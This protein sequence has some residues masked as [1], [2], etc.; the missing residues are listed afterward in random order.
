[1]KL[2]DVESRSML[3]AFAEAQRHADEMC[4]P[5]PIFKGA[6]SPW[7][8]MLALGIAALCVVLAVS[9]V[10]PDWFLSD[11]VA[12]PTERPLGQQLIRDRGD[13]TF[14]DSHPV[15]GSVAASRSPS[16]QL[17]TAIGGAD[18]RIPK[19]TGRSIA[20]ELIN[21]DPA[22]AI[23]RLSVLT[24]AVVHGDV[25]AAFQGTRLTMRID[26]SSPLEAWRQ[27][28]DG[29]NYSLNCH[30]SGCQVWLM[31]NSVTGEPSVAEPA[32]TAVSPSGG[33]ETSG[34][35]PASPAGA[36]R[37]IPPEKLV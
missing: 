33:Q 16:S 21:A 13:A 2:H 25:A 32:G 8:R 12:Q 18:D 11:D 23:S 35:E 9:L 10:V 4:R 30:S 36:D 19:V 17:P 29:L 6:R 31:D 20:L 14:A 7:R 1:M 5:P 22:Q 37:P 26:A 24:S 15:K 28:L 3:S 34:A 27:L